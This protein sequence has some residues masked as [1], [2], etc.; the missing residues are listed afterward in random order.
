MDTE[1]QVHVEELTKLPDFLGEICEE[2]FLD[3]LSFQYVPDS[4]TMFRGVFSLPPAHYFFKEIGRNME[5]HRYWQV[6][7]SP[8]TQSLPPV[9]YW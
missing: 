2:S 9:I 4:R 6:N 3:Y 7:F 5:M 1:L 8:G